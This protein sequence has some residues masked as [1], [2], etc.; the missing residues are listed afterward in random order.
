MKIFI[1]LIFA[2][3]F[4]ALLVLAWQGI[5][6]YQYAHRPTSA[7]GAEEIVAVAPGEKFTALAAK[8]EQRGIITQASK[9]IR[10]AL[11][12]GVDKKLKSGEYPLTATMTPVE[13]LDVLVSGKSYLY[14][15]T[16][17]EGFT[18][19]QIAEQ[20]AAIGLGD[21][22]KFIA[23]AT[24]AEYAATLNIEAD[25]LEGYLFPDTYYFPKSAS[26]DTII[27]QMADR[28]NEQ[29]I[30]K[31]RLRAKD[32]N[33][34]IHEIVTLASI[35]EKETGDPS[36]RPIIA[37]VFHNR[38]RKRMRLESDPTV[39]YGIPDFDGNIKRIHLATPTPYNTYKIRGLP[40]GPIAN[41]GREAIKA[42]LYPAKTD[43]L[44]F[45]SK[46]DSTHQFS[47]NIR[48]HQKAV[49]KYQLRRRKKR[50]P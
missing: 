45:V 43:Y 4:I 8:L 28:F 10:L 9:F 31:W 40:P 38:L 32:L 44:F 49:R 15:L 27:R 50:R 16:I 22:E 18:L 47:T 14:R 41:P 33:R 7:D 25:T 46:K 26:E 17:P 3:A 29:F 36:E 35:I 11:I 42:A 1:K 30:P 24:S 48:D 37:S 21:A 2:A 13:V 20:V 39:I 19:R 34:S 5:S 6:L 23:L 12:K